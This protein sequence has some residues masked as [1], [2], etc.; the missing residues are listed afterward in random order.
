MPEACSQSLA[1]PPATIA[2]PSGDRKVRRHITS[3]DDHNLEQ[4]KIAPI[5]GHQTGYPVMPL[6]S[7]TDTRPMDIASTLLDAQQ[8]QI[9]TQV[10]YAA[11]KKILDAQKQA[12]NAAIELLQAAAQ[13]V[14]TGPSP[15]GLGAAVDVQG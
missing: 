9:G 4:E 15:D 13:T 5:L 11:A 6:E 1:A 12:G 14:P 10:A 3:P 8:S 7:N 2:R